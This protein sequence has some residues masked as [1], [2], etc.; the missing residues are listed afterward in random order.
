M[1]RTNLSIGRVTIY[2]ATAVIAM[3]SACSALA[4][5]AV[6]VNPKNPAASM[7]AADV[8]NI[9]L[10]KVS[11]LTTVDLPEGSPIRDAFYQKVTNKN[12]VQV[13]SIWA[14]L[15]FT[16]AAFPP[17]QAASAEEVKKIVSGDAKAIGY[18]DKSAIDDSVKAI[19][20]VN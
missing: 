3:G 13:K 11:G 18:I 6:I 9:Y 5:I 10:G 16:G 4:D 14:R 19:L 7:G 17:K 20:V 2:T 15:V 12:A 8:A 1:S